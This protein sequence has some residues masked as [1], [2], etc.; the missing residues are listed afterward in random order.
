MKRT[1]VA[2]DARLIERIRQ[3]ATLEGRQFQQCVNELLAIGL[4]ASERPA[5]EHRSLPSFSMGDANVDL[6]DREALYDLME[7]R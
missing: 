7:G 4:A 1:T 2:L 3:R 5:H 6:A